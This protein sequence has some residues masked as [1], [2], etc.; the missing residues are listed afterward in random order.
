MASGREGEPIKWV[1]VLPSPMNAKYTLITGKEYFAEGIKTLCDSGYPEMALNAVEMFLGRSIP[2][3]VG[4]LDFIPKSCAL[5]SA[6]EVTGYDDSGYFF[7]VLGYSG[8]SSDRE[9]VCVFLDDVNIYGRLCTFREVERVWN[10]FRE[11]K[12][13]EQ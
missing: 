12:E 8:S 6:K 11:L 5:L 10:M 1:K 2:I 9:F 7:A 3:I 4:H 13:N